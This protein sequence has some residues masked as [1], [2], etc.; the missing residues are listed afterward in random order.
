M[1]WPT[2]GA[3][4]GTGICSP[5]NLS[6]EPSCS[7]PSRSTGYQWNRSWNWGSSAMVFG[8]LTGATGKFSSTPKSIH[9]LAVL[10]RKMSRSS[11][12]SSRLPRAWSAY[13]EP[14]HRSNRSVRSTAS[15]KFFQKACSE[16]MNRT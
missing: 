16:A 14:G 12:R 11:A 13:F 9:A 3:W 1:C 15:Q 6:G 7:A 5:M 8:E 2:V 4:A 10:V